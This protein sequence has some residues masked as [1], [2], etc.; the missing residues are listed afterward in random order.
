MTEL[1]LFLNYR[2][3]RLH[4]RSVDRLVRRSVQK[5]IN[6]DG[7]PHIL[8]HSVATHLL[9]RGAGICDIQ[10]F[11]GHVKLSTTA[12]YTHLDAAH[13]VALY[14]RAHPRALMVPAARR[15]E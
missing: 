10:V 1:A 8:R 5:A 11:L 13:L 12:R 7:S 2:G 4:A 14:R 15:Q 6:R 9:E 3:S